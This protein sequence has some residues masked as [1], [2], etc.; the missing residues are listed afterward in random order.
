MFNTPLFPIVVVETSG[1]LGAVGVTVICTDEVL[2][3]VVVEPLVLT[4]EVFSVP[5]LQV[6]LPF[7]AE[8]ELAHPEPDALFMVDVVP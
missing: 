2:V 8:L 3:N 7:A 1:G 4:P 6:K 5:R